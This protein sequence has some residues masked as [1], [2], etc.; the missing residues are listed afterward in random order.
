MSF[1]RKG[2]DALTPAYR[3]RLERGGISQSRYEAGESLKQARGH[4]PKPVTPP[5]PIIP[6]LTT[7]ELD[8]YIEKM[9]DLYRVPEYV[10]RQDLSG[11]SAERLRDAVRLQVR[12]EEAYHTDHYA[13]ATALWEQRDDSLPDWMNRYHSWFN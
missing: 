2:W 5:K 4:K 9:R 7:D 6:P 3:K 12:M 8:D 10:I 1:R 11:L 13:D